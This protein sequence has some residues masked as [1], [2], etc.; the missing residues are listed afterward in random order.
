M[1]SDSL[2]KIGYDRIRELLARET[3]SGAGK[4]RARS[5]QPLLNPSEVSVRQ[6]QVS[7]LRSLLDASAP[8]PLDEFDDV[9]TQLKR[10]QVSGAYFLADQLWQIQRVLELCDHIGQYYRAHAEKLQS[11]RYLISNLKSLQPVRQMILRTVDEEGN[12]RDGASREL[13]RIRQGMQRQIKQLHRAIERLMNTARSENWLHEENPT[14]REG[15]LVLPLRT[16]YKRKIHGIIHGQSATAATTYVEPLEI[17]EINNMLKDLEQEEKAEI[18]RILMG[19]TDSIRP[20]FEDISE[21][22]R[23]LIE[24]DFL[25]A[26]AKFAR[27]FKCQCP[28]IREENRSIVLKQARHPLLML[29][30]EV[31]PL[32]LKLAADT[33]T[34]ILTGP[35]AGGKT[36]AMK[37]VGLLSA[38]A[39]SGLQIPADEGCILPFFDSFLID[40]G[41]QQSLENDLSTFSSHVSN[42][43]QFVE[44]ATPNSLVLIDELGTGTEPIEGAALGEAVLEE[45]IQC[46]ATT[47]VTTHH[48]ALK[49]FAEKTPAVVNAAMEFDTRSLTPSYRLQLGIPGSSYALEIATRLGLR[50]DVIERARIIMGGDSVKLENLLLEVESLRGQLESKE[51]SVAL[52][53]KTLDKLVGEYEEKLRQIREKHAKFDRELAEK[54]ES[55]VRESRARI[56]NTVKDIREKEADRSTVKEAQKVVADIEQEVKTRKRKAK[57]K[58]KS[59]QKEKF[60]EGQWVR[61]EGFQDKG[62][63]VKVTPRGNRIGVEVE[64]KTVWVS[65]EVLTPTRLSPK[66]K[67]IREPIYAVHV[68]E[69][70]SNR[71]D[72]RGMRV[73]EAESALIQFLD[74]A[75]LANLNYLEIIH[76]KGTGALQKMV[77]AELKKYKDVKNF[78]FDHFDRGGTGATIVEL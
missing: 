4:E 49:A 9:R 35:N 10:C 30:K 74:R 62:R 1:A 59:S 71:L 72:L 8:L 55:V 51:R 3:I 39:M 7:A 19:I 25:Y 58:R 68:S 31:V 29:V 17:V 73:D 44:T 40:I 54:M 18:R 28:E 41:D 53:K 20:H 75:I 78:R 63:I 34:M 66:E 14:I 32:D 43:K 24:L 36:V 23:T 6:N 60:Q 47:I 46:G 22:V 65:N 11:L 69:P 16:E 48:T 57:I 26:C 77:W 37:C 61:I 15:R 5:L 70:G 2:T 76:G 45:L 13:G 27:R 33:R 67:R 21:I 52:N 56:E 42:L 50:E 64:G 12:V 38:M